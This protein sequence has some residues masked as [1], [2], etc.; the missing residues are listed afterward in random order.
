MTRDPEHRVT[1]AHRK[2]AAIVYLRQSSEKQVRDHRESARVQLGLREKAV[3]LGWRGPE[4]IGDDLGVSAA[5]FAHRPGFQQL[6]TR[7]TLK[8]VGII[9]CVDASR[10]SRNSRDWAHLFELCSFFG[11]L[12]ADMEQVYDL[13]M[14][15][16]RL[17]LGIK[18]TVSELEL[19]LIKARMK[20]GLEAK[21]ARG[22]L[23]VLLPAGYVYDD[24][25]R[26][27]F[28]PDRRAQAAIRLMFDQ[29]D[30]L[31][32]LRELAAWYRDTGTR[33]PVRRR[34]AEQQ[35]SWRVPTSRTLAKLLVHPI[36]AG[37]YVWGRRVT[38]VDYDDGRLV[39]RVR[40]PGSPGE[41]RVCIRNHHPAYVS[42]SRIVANVTRLAENKARWKMDDNLCAIREGLALLPG[43]LRCRTCGSKVY[44]SY[45]KESAL[46]F[47]DAGQ[48]KGSRRCMSFGSQTIDRL[49]SAE[50]LRALEPCAVDASIAARHIFEKEREQR[51]ESLR[52]QVEAARYEADR[53]FQQFD[54]VDPRHRLVADTLE[55]RLNEKLVELQAAKQRLE[56]AGANER[57]LT[58]EDLRRLDE[59]AHHFPAVW[60]HPKA[61][62]KLKKRILRTVIRE[63]L[64]EHQPDQGRLEVTI[65]WQG[66]AHT[67]LHVKKRQKRL[68][69][70][71]DP[72]LVAT[73][74]K[75]AADGVRDDEAARVLNLMQTTTPRGL[76]W[77]QNRML[78]FRKHHRIRL[79]PPP[80]PDEVLTK[81][82]AVKYL[83][84]SGNGLLG[85][86]REGAISRNQVTDFAPWRV[87]RE[88]L[89]SEEVQAL[90]R[91]LKATGR[92][93]K[94]GCSEGQLWLLD[95][96]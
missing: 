82:E 4:V 76:P 40:Q 1:A 39:K 11:T 32:S 68:G 28:D 3:A 61:D 96:E 38:E 31:T 62:P 85:L 55:N 23:K 78:S 56:E 75:L 59:L 17:V 89:D 22:E 46:Y 34:A 87:K 2:R 15:N 25:D 51:L 35:T 8:E 37:A 16:D 83:G 74:R 20:G 33:F 88:Q 67:Q 63:I 72:D 12:I 52:M 90:V 36:Y 50:V 48:G 92:V 29:F 54:R 24:Q 84:I 49:V 58:E 10:L 64:V 44:V 47:C 95:D 7:V 14:P 81:Q 6:I 60:H 70:A 41:S 30:R 79:A 80:S 13:S 42:W 45:K 73:A 53:A 91:A 19:N 86:E 93:P 94:G 18:G 21:A 77:T 27:V 69:G 43:L 65:H 66:G 26:M 5:G 9:L 71:T 57:R